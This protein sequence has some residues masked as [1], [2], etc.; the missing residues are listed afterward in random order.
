M[1]TAN[2][3]TTSMEATSR[4][5]A[6]SIPDEIIGFFSWPNPSSRSMALGSIQ[7]LTEISTRNLPGGKGRP[8]READNLT[9]IS[10][11]IV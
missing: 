6:G 11:P 4:K 2:I 10:E 1:R 7:P 3:N 9:A 5:V 8:V